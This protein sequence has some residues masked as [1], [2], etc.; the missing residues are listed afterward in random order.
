[1]V[2]S[3]GEFD[4]AITEHAIDTFDQAI[5]KA[6]EYCGF[7]DGGFIDEV[8]TDRGSQFYSN[9]NRPSRFERHL[10]QGHYPHTL[11]GELNVSR[12]CFLGGGRDKK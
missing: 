10:E 9:K 12:E 11:R 7:I 5:L 8:N 6:E 3:C 1:M 4:E 2:L